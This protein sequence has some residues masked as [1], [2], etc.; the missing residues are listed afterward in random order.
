MVGK[1]I[2]IGLDKYDRLNNQSQAVLPKE[3]FK[4]EKSKRPKSSYFS[5]K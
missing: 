3:D 5:D 4:V 2:S 1:D